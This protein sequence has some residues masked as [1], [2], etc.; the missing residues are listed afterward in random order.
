MQQK[1]K[2]YPTY[3]PYSPL[4]DNDL[5]FTPRANIRNI[6]LAPIDVILLEFKFNSTKGWTVS[7]KYSDNTIQAEPSMELDSK[8]NEVKVVLD[9]NETANAL[10]KKKQS[11]KYKYIG[12]KK[13]STRERK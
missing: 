13:N 11:K 2:Q 12:F 1:R 9:N 3:L 7:N 10:W 4:N 5:I 8:D 6:L